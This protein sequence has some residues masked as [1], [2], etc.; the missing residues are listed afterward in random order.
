[1]QLDF[2]N[3]SPKYQKL[4]QQNKFVVVDLETTGFAPQKYAKILEISAIQLTAAPMDQRPHFDTLINPRIKIPKKIT[5]LT[6]ITDAEVAHKPYLVDVISPFYK[7][8]DDAIIIAHNATFEKRFLT[9][10]FETRGYKFNNQMFDTKKMLQ[11]LCPQL[12]HY[13]LDDLTNCFGVTNQHHHRACADTEA[14]AQAFLKARQAYLQNQE[15]DIPLLKS[16]PIPATTCPYRD[17]GGEHFNINTIAAWKKGQYS[18]LYVNGTT[19]DGLYDNP[20]YDFIEKSWV[21]PQ[22]LPLDFYQL[23]LD[24]IHQKKVR[25]LHELAK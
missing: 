14:T 12:P 1:M 4:L 25:K 17:W 2:N 24:I 13:Q 18:R 15:L 6:S 7:F 20:Y 21:S 16:F 5:K 9:Y 23:T 3:L 19:D 11:E 10:A 8:L 22:Q